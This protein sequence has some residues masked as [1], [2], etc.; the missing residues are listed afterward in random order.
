MEKHFRCHVLKA[1]EIVQSLGSA[2]CMNIVL[3]GGMV[4][5]LDMDNIDW[6]TVIAET[7]PEKFRE[8]NLRA[9]RAGRDAVNK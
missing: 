7:V 9:Y 8:L 5:A 6:E 1:G 3:F 4:K 2:K